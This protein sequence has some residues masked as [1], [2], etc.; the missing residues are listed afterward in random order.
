MGEYAWYG[1]N[2]GTQTHPV[3]QKIPNRLGLHDMTGNVEEWCADWYDENY[4]E[5]SP[6]DNPRGPGNGQK[7]VLRG[8]AWNDSPRYVRAAYRY[9]SDPTSRF[10]YYGFRLGLSAR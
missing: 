2:L 8:G 10:V 4:Y 6:K 7:R 1:S 3:G 9:R 5:K